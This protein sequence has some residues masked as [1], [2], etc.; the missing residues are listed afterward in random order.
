MGAVQGNSH[1]EDRG[2]SLGVADDDNGPERTYFF[3][4][5]ANDELKVVRFLN[6][7][8]GKVLESCS[9]IHWKRIHRAVRTPPSTVDEQDTNIRVY[10]AGRRDAE[11]VGEDVA[12]WEEDACHR[13]VQFRRSAHFEEL[14]ST[15]LKLKT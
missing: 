2:A 13:A 10:L 11:V 7:A 3:G 14:N 6:R 1:L 9:Q 8:H 4:M 15:Q 12:R 5:L